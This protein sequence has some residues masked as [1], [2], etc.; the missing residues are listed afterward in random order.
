MLPFHLRRLYALMYC[1]TPLPSPP[2]TPM[3]INIILI[4]NVAIS[5]ASFVR[6]NVL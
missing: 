1:K 4:Q 5:S 2:L 3:C 6:I